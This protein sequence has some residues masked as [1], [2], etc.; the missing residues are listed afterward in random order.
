MEDKI[1]YGLEWRHPN[2]LEWNEQERYTTL[3]KARLGYKRWTKEDDATYVRPAK[4]RIV[5]TTRKVVR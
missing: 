1:R 4:W 2:E 5:K 3:A